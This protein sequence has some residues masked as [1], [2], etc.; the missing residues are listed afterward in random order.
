MNGPNEISG[1][2]FEK[3]IRAEI[4]SC[5]KKGILV[6]E[7]NGVMAAQIWRDSKRE[8]F[9]TRSMPDMTGA[10]RDGKRF[11][12]DAKVCGGVS[13]PLTPYADKGKR[14]RQLT[15][16]YRYSAVGSI[17]G[18]LIHFTAREAGKRS[19]RREPGTWF[20]PINRDLEFWIEFERGEHKSITR[21]KVA[22]NSTKVE[23]HGMNA[24]N[25]TGRPNLRGLFK[26]LEE[27]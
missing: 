22:E 1:K 25:P 26:M 21:D 12:F 24:R 11:D 16:G 27:K 18:F 8:V 3:R 15:H 6:G 17:Q 19:P 20:V 23:W 14:R 5:E 2:D 13:F 9:T 7:K 4:T 10:T